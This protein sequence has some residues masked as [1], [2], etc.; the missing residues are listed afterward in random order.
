MLPSQNQQDVVE[1]SS[2]D[3]KENV[4]TNLENKILPDSETKTIRNKK[5]VT[6]VDIDRC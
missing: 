4:V 2:R 1:I 6:E 5:M 3:E